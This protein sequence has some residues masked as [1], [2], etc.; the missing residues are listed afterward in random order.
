MGAI[1]IP[2]L[3]MKQL[4]PEVLGKLLSCTGSGGS[5][6]STQASSPGL[7]AVNHALHG[8]APLAAPAQPRGLWL[9]QAFSEGNVCSSKH[10]ARVISLSYFRFLIVPG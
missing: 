3:E 7:G 2:F 9:P 6:I 4:R 5:R 1:I 10:V 8:P